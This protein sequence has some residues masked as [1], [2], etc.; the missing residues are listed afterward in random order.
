MSA[1]VPDKEVF[2]TAPPPYSQVAAPIGTAPLVGNYPP[3]YQSPPVYPTGP[4]YPP[5]PAQPYPSQATVVYTSGALGPG[6]S[7]FFCP[8]CQREV[9][10]NV[11]YESGALTWLLVVLIFFLGGF[12]GCCLIPLCCDCDKDAVHSCP[13]CKR[14][15]G[16][17][18]RL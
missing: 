14:P 13:H 17:F 12:M 5:P 1:P 11:T 6:P 4:G 15:L 9:L 3:G 7:R 8:T 16:N 18:R 2:P 10:T